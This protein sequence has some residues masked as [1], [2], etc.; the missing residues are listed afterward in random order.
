MVGGRSWRLD[1][2]M[3]DHDAC[4]MLESN[5]TKI[6]EIK[7][8]VRGML[9]ERAALVE[10]TPDAK[11]SGAPAAVIS[12]SSYWTDFCRQFEYM[13]GLPEEAFDKLRNHTY[14]LTSDN[15]QTYYFGDPIVFRRVTSYDAVTAGLPERFRLGEPENGIGFKLDGKI[16]SWDIVRFQRAFS[17]LYRQGVLDK[18]D[19]L[20]RRRILEI[21]G[22][23]GGIAHQ[24]GKAF[25]KT[26]YVIIDLPETLVFSASYLALHNPD[27][28]IYIYDN[29]TFQAVLN[30]VDVY[31]FI[32]VPNYVL[33]QLSDFRFDLV[34]NIASL[35]E[36]RRSQAEEYLD[37]IKR[38]SDVFYSDNQD[39]Q[40]KNAE[41]G[42][43]YDLLETR[44]HLVELPEET[45]QQGNAM[46]RLLRTTAEDVV[47][48]V[49][50]RPRAYMPPTRRIICRPL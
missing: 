46:I 36:M 22:G 45:D 24:L 26:T 7:A 8:R 2:M 34:V 29:Q 48:K 4:E 27:R 38:T 32:L 17:A 13:L 11:A 35:Q 21:G 20:P 18:L 39:H 3:P 23:Y 14:H 31:D 33:K 12:P 44:F 30:D 49:V 16:V 10:H 5:V 15:Y 37:F 28:K 43:L 47:R 40:P 9:E 19:A 1:F 41:L 50:N 42:K 6:R 25:P